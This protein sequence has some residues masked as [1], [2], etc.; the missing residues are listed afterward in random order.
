MA[1]RAWKPLAG[2]L[3]NELVIINGKI[4]LSGTVFGGAQ[5]VTVT[6]TFTGSIPTTLSGSNPGILAS[7]FPVTRLGTGSYQL[8]LKDSYNAI[9]SVQFEPFVYA[10]LYSISVVGNVANTSTTSSL[11]A[12]GK[13]Q[14]NTFGF[15]VLSGSSNGPVLYDPTGSIDIYCAL[16]LKNS[17]V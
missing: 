3:D 14:G 15:F 9:K 2:T 7:T 6:S 1:N 10:P 5:A 13:S 11:N 4:N 12:S 16:A 8:A 17:S